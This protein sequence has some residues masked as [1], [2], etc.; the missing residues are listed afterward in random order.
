MSKKKN[1]AEDDPRRARQEAQQR[2][3]YRN[4]LER[5]IAAGRAM[6]VE[7]TK[8]ILDELEKVKKRKAGRPPKA[9]IKPKP[10]ID[11][12]E[13]IIGGEQKRMDDAIDMLNLSPEQAADVRARADK[14]EQL[15]HKLAET[16]DIA[17]K[18]I[19][20]AREKLIVPS[21]H[22]KNDGLPMEMPPF[23][24]DFT[25]KAFAPGISESLLCVSRKNGKTS[26]TSAIL[27]GLCCTRAL[28]EGARIA[29]VSLDKKK[30]AELMTH[31][32]DT[33]NASG[34]EVKYRVQ[35]YP[36]RVELLGTEI[37]VLSAD[38]N[39]GHAG[40]YNVVV[41]DEL[42]LMKER[43]R[44]LLSGLRS[45]TST[46]RGRMMFLSIHGDGPF[47]PEIIER[48]ESGA[49]SESLHVSIYRGR[50]GAH[51]NDEANWYASNP[52]L[53]T[54]KDLEHMRKESKRVSVTR[55]DEADFRAFELNED[56]DPK[57]TYIVTA[58][59]WEACEVERSEIDD[60]APREGWCYVGLDAGGSRSMSAMVAYWPDTGRMEVTGMF[61]DDPTL[62]ERGRKD[63]V[64]KV[65][66]EMERLGELRTVPGRVSDVPLMIG[67]FAADLQGVDVRFV[68]FDK[69]HRESIDQKLAEADNSWVRRYRGTGANATADGSHDVRAFQEAVLTGRIKT[70]KGLML[71]HC[72]GNAVLRFDGAG[73]P[74]LDKSSL[75]R[76]IDPVSAAVI[77]VG[78]AASDAG[79]REA[80]RDDGEEQES[81]LV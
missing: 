27:I 3:Y 57:K 35:P 74:A 70:P 32:V 6:G 23:L 22:F 65:Y 36:G 46:R 64:G 63:G 19:I 4:K 38:S 56:L 42:G 26:G 68:G 7:P 20:F 69:Y 41:V 44:S 37:E 5:K 62:S 59:D 13:P 60:V 1:F 25:R 14:A 21:G 51:L 47:I 15:R 79:V 49:E 33:C 39:A 76:R 73:N 53:G 75:K 45:S 2:R 40:G 71:M 17:E 30:A 48:H 24:E 67:D 8:E 16:D 54:I 34:I 55:A 29:C 9:S 12:F 10:K 28:G 11:G 81:F 72:I 78:L 50:K 61:G 18:L 43:N 80:Y 58:S 31:I 52:G 66:E 77:A